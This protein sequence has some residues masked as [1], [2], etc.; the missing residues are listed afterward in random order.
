MD[1]HVVKNNGAKKA[2][3]CCNGSTLKGK[4]IKYAK[5]YRYMYRMQPVCLNKE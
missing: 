3:S 2:R 4:G 1:T 5:H